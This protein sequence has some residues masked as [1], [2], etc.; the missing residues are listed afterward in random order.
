MKSKQLLSDIALSLLIFSVISTVFVIGQNLGNGIVTGKYFWFYFSTMLFAIIAIPVAVVRKVTIRFALPDMLLFLFCLFAIGITYLKTGRFPTKSLLL[1]FLLGFW[2]SLRICLVGR[3]KQMLYLLS[4][5]FMITGLT[6]AI[7]GLWQLYGIAESQHYIFP[8]TGSFFNSGPYAGWLAIVLPVA[9]GCL[10]QCFTQNNMF[11]FHK[12]GGKLIHKL[13]AFLK[14]RLPF[15]IKISV[16][17]LTVTS[18][19]LV[20]P[21]SISRAS[22][23]AAFGGTVFVV[24]AYYVSNK[25]VKDYFRT[26]KKLII[27]L[28][29]VIFIIMVIVLK[30]LFML[31]VNSATGRVLIWKTTVSAITQ[32]PAGVGLG[33]FGGVYGETQ[34]AYFASGSSSEK[35]QYVAGIVEYAFNEYLQ[36]CTETGIIGF[37][38]F[39]TFAGLTLFVGIRRGNYVFTGAFIALLIFAAMSYPFNILPFVIIFVFLAALIHSE[40]IEIKQTEYAKHV[41]YNRYIYIVSCI[42][43]V[44]CCCLYLPHIYKTYEAYKAWTKIQLL[45]QLNMYS[46]ATAEYKKQ[47]QYLRDEIKFVIEYEQCLSKTGQ[48]AESNKIIE[49]ALQISCNPGLLIDMGLNYQV[50]KQYDLAEKYFLKSANMAPNLLYP[51]YM[52]VKLYYEA[53]RFNEARE[54]IHIALSKKMKVNSKAVEKI[55][56]ELEKYKLELEI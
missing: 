41:K 33:N 3:S 40:D 32:H 39:I 34:A 8:L 22:W 45:Y 50:L 47:Y 54:M 43:V 24:A 15:W 29:I 14:A 36:I 23:L 48:Y 16:G 55:R 10:R 53:E 49:T 18:I 35:E 20:L 6:E 30:G 5:F 26:H 51:F 37:L 7:W 13:L 11:N 9:V 44:M 2:F 42:T 28:F 21:A 12:S 46:E 52:L 4:L 17:I 38:I 56:E 1:V 25:N 19:L 31:K 27:L